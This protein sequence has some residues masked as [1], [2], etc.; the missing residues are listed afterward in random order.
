MQMKIYLD[1]CI[2]SGLAKE[3]ISKKEYD[4]LLELLRL[5]KNTKLQIFTSELAKAELE[6]IPESYRN[7]HLVIYNL[8][9]DVTSID[10]LVLNISP[11]RIGLPVRQHT[12]L[13]QLINILR[14]EE[15]A[16][17]I[18]QASRNNIEYFVTV[19]ERTILVKAN[20]I[21]DIS[22]V[23]VILPS[24]CLRIYEQSASN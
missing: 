20:E 5:Q 12:V 1:T 11:A 23:N 14:D 19:D 16:K 17:H 18:Y 4:S 13:A 10:Y 8:L 3:D 2:I 24:D 6:K 15:D 9:T 21:L 22:N 7:K